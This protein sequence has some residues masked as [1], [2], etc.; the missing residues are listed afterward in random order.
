VAAIKL[1]DLERAEQIYTLLEPYP[2]HNTPDTLLLD[3]GS[4]SHYL[5]LLAELLGWHDRVEVHFRTALS[6]N[7]DMSRR[8]QLA[9]TYYDYAAWLATQDRAGASAQAQQLG[10]EAYAHAEALG[11]HWLVQAA[12]SLMT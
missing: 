3:E 1:R 12:R 8:P 11:M 2:Q 7:R 6:M 9:R 5:A 10:R 4:V